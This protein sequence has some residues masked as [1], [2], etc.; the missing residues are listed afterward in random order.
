[1]P[2]NVVCKLKMSLYGLKHASKQW[3]LK[4]CTTM[5]ALRFQQSHSDHTLF[6]R[7]DSTI[8]I[9][10]LV[11][12]DDII[13]ASNNDD[14]VVHLKTNMKSFFNLRDLGPLRH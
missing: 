2:P 6:I 11:Y 12:V 7:H 5:L 13:I 10:V 9:V 8:Y 1:M 4:F 14:D 3:F